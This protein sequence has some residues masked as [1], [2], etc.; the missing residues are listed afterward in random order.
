METTVTSSGHAE[1]DPGAALQRLLD[2]SAIEA[3]LADYCRG[4]DRGD[5]ALVRSAYHDDAIEHHGAFRGR[6]PDDFIEYAEERNGVFRSVAHYVC[7]HAIEFEGEVA[8]SEA[9]VLAVHTGTAEDPTLQVTFGGRYVDRFERR[10]GRWA[11]ADR[12]VVADWSRVDH[13]EEWERGALF[14]QGIAGQGDVSYRRLPAS[15]GAGSR[16]DLVPRGG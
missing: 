5:L 8:Y 7:N 2:R 11:I 1:G 6:N 10:E 14:L 16:D 13:V 9:Y 15:A 3:A 4:V 12:A